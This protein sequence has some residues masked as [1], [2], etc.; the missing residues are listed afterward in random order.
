MF[1]IIAP[2]WLL[3]I[4]YVIG[5]IPEKTATNI[6]KFFFIVFLFVIPL[7]F[8]IFVGGNKLIQNVNAPEFSMSGIFEQSEWKKTEDGYEVFNQNIWIQ[9]H[10]YGYGN[11]FPNK[12]SLRNSIS[13]VFKQQNPYKFNDRVLVSIYGKSYE[14]HK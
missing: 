10:E 13:E 8:L 4:F 7:L 1:I 2:L 11:E 9:T 6:I 3:I 12:D 14:I 5:S